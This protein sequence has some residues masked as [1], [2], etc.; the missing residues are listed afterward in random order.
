MG[1]HEALNSKFKVGL[2]TV[3]NIPLIK[4]GDDIARIIYQCAKEDGFVFQSHD[5]VVVTHKIVSK[6][7]NARVR[8]AEITPSIYAR[9]LAE[10][11]GRDPR[12]CQVYINESKEILGIN[13]R[14]VVTRHRLGF[15][16]TGGGVDSSNMGTSKEEIV[17]L[18]P[19][20]PDASARKIR[21]KLK[22]LARKELAVIICD[23]FGNEFR[24]YSISFAIGIAGIHPKAVIDTEDLF[25]RPKQTST[26][27]VDE[28]AA[29]AGMLMGQAKESVPVVV[30][31]G[32]KYTVSEDASTKDILI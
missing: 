8:L 4:G 26:A 22:R 2:Y 5:I 29:A 24:N 21:S 18:L 25:D 11:T 30:V 32:I 31:R 15:V 19:K 14:H 23:T 7:E 17:C 28:I 10:K 6:A 3:P 16:G 27:Q 13:G 12:L 20:D 9:E 1:K